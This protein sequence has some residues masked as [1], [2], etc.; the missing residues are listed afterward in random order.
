MTL[1]APHEAKNLIVTASSLN[2]RSGNINNLSSSSSRGPAVDGRIVPTITAPGQQIASARNDLGGLCATA[3]AGTNNLYAFCSGTSMATPHASGAVVLLTEWWRTLNAGANPSP[4]M[5]KALLVN[6]AVDMGTADIPNFNEGWG[7][8]NVTNVIT[9]AAPVEYWDQETLL[10]STGEQFQVTVSV[11]DPTRPVKVTL[12]WSDAAGAVGANPALV[13]NLDLTV[14]DG[15]NTYL[16]NRFTA[17]WSA[18]GGTPDT[19]NNL[20]NVYIQTPSSGSIDVTV[21]ATAINGDGVP[22]NG[23]GTD[24][25]F[26]LVCSNCDLSL[27]FSDGFETGDTS[28]WSQ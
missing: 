18:T 8:V 26:A 15:A 9:P 27:L 25:D 11:P 23:D 24:Q 4:A 2:A 6:G 7:R 19:R 28:R 10:A 3:I 22:Y 17:G 21:A 20:E 1:T 14:V 12:V 5:A 13:N 16:G